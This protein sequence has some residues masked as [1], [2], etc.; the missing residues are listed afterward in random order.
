[1][2]ACHA[3][4]TLTSIRRFQIDTSV[5]KG[6]DAGMRKYQWE[7]MIDLTHTTASHIHPSTQ[8]MEGQCNSLGGGYGL[9]S[10]R[11][12]SIIHRGRKQNYEEEVDEEDEEE[13]RTNLPI[14]RHNQ[15]EGR[16]SDMLEVLQCQA[17]LKGLSV[18]NAV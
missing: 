9:E 6:Q 8:H 11:Y 18:A 12:Y 13:G 4:G 16:T 15:G 2:A 7:G 10:V 1:M 3:A 17:R 14:S 5:Y